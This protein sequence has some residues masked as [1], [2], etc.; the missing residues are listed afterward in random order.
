MQPTTSVLRAG[1]EGPEVVDLQYLLASSGT[2]HASSL[3]S[4]D[5]KFGP[6]TETAVRDFQTAKRLV[7]DG[8]VGQKTWAT[9]F[10][11]K[12]WPT[13]SPGTFLRQGDSGAEE[14]QIGLKSKGFYN[15]EIDGDFGPKTHTA[16][17]KAQTIGDIETNTEGVVGPIT[18]GGVVGC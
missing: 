13:H 2:I 1:S 5:G 3:G 8:V 11:A 17:V 18:F 12:S 16:V 14:L 15:G 6:K 10:D 4:A 7:D 9:F